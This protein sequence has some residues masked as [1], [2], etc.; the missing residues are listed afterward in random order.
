MSGWVCIVLK[1]S[2]EPSSHPRAIAQGNQF[3]TERKGP[4]CCNPSTHRDAELWFS[5]LPHRAIHR[6]YEDGRRRPISPRRAHY[7]FRNY[8]TH[9]TVQSRFLDDAFLKQCWFI[10]QC[11]PTDAFVHHAAI[12]QKVSVSVALLYI[13]NL[14]HVPSLFTS[15]SPISIQN[16]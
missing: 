1:K 14:D 16:P 15:L 13:F 12:L 6:F 5:R 7:I 11:D 9:T 3:L 10:K 4:T 8:S 2:L